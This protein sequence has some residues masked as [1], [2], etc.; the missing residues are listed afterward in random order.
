MANGLTGP[1]PIIYKYDLYAFGL[2][3]RKL[4]DVYTEAL[5]KNILFDPRK[6]RAK[7]KKKSK[8]KRTKK[9]SV[10][11]G[12]I[13][14]TTKENFKDLDD[15]NYIINN[16][17]NNDCIYRWSLSDLIAYYKGEEIDTEKYINI[18]GTEHLLSSEKV[19]RKNIMKQ[20]QI[21]NPEISE[22]VK[23]K[24]KPKEELPPVNWGDI[25][26]QLSAQG[27]SKREAKKEIEKMKRIRSVRTLT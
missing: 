1:E 27:L 19:T 3:L 8:K 7:T 23:P 24:S 9:S 4:V 16:M 18:K 6:H 14:E 12:S 13:L 17:I 26:L 5:N 15:I 22:Y 11:G 20:F 10:S 21:V 2:I 25:Q